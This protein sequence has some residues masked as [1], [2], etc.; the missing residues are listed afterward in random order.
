MPTPDKTM[1]D[2]S[3]LV[4]EARGRALKAAKGP[5]HIHEGDLVTADHKDVFLDWEE[6]D[7]EGNSIGPDTVFICNAQPDVLALCDAL[8]SVAKERDERHA[9]VNELADEKY[10]VLA[11][12][13]ALTKERDALREALRLHMLWIGPPPT[14]RYS[15]DSLREDAWKLGVELIGNPRA[16][17]AAQS[18]P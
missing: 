18:K 11:Q 9:R 12:R 4:A 6:E 10:K 14:D 15:F 16:A 3:K 13:D 5:W 17:L 7:D 8:E 2:V 1:N